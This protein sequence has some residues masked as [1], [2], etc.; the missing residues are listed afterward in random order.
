MSFMKTCVFTAVTTLVAATFAGCGGSES[1]YK[2]NPDTGKKEAEVRYAL[3]GIPQG[4]PDWECKATVKVS[5]NQTKTFDSSGIRVAS[6]FLP[7]GEYTADIN[8]TCG[9]RFISCSGVSTQY[10]IPVIERSGAFGSPKVSIP[11]QAVNGFTAKDKF[12]IKDKS[13]LASKQSSPEKSLSKSVAFNNAVSTQAT[14][15]NLGTA[16]IEFT[17]LEFM[18]KDQVVTCDLDHR[19]AYYGGYGFHNVEVTNEGNNTITGWHA[20]IDFGDA[21][22]TSVQWTVNAEASI[23]ETG[24]VVSGDEVLAPGESATFSIGGQYKGQ[25][26]IDT[27]CY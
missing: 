25:N 9:C 19:K 14:A 3:A 10:W 2:P 20:Y 23:S 13:L 27:V 26:V 5:G 16:A 12:T 21:S 4:I 1:P 7:D 8:V 6:F 22:P 24:V 17:L 18:P 11:G 15:S